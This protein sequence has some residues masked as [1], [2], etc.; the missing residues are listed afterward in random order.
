MK[1]NV[2]LKTSA[3][4]RLANLFINF[5]KWEVNRKISCKQSNQ[6]FYKR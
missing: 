1:K 6:Y 5:G 2:I 3:Q 4:Q